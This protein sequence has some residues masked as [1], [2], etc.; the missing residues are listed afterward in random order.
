DLPVAVMASGSPPARAY[1]RVAELLLGHGEAG[2]GGN[3][4]SRDSARECLDAWHRGEVAKP[5]HLAAFS[6]PGPQPD[7][8]WTER[9]LAGDAEAAL[10]AAPGRGLGKSLLLLAVGAVLGA[11]LTVAV[12]LGPGLPFPV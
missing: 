4:K 6:P 12:L 7:P 8:V 5:T 9:E 2:E 10:T 1:V 3:M 11:A